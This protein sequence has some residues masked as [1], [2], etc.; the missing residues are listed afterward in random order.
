MGKHKYTEGASIRDKKSFAPFLAEDEELILATGYGKNYLRHKFAY[1]LL[2]PGGIALILSAVIAYFGEYNLGYALLFGLVG[3]GI[4]AYLKTLHAY[5]SH[6][7]ILTTRRV[8]IKN[9]FFAVKLTSALFDK[10]THIE[11]DQG[12][13]DR[14]VMKHGNILINTAGGS[15]DEI[16][17]LNIDDPIAFKNL[18]ERLINRERE[19]FGGSGLEE[20]PGLW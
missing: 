4:L 19:R 5:H 1:Y 17:L 3:A 20:H 14:M 10:V 2:W 6:R 7:Y 16:K 13:M 18:M 15:K 11:V 8:I 9:G 12:F